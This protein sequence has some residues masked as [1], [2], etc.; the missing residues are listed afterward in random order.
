VDSVKTR[1]ARKVSIPVGDGLQAVPRGPDLH[2][3]AAAAL[4][5]PGL[6]TGPYRI[7]QRLL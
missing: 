3:N 6:K 1:K 7:T 4:G 2:P 5:T